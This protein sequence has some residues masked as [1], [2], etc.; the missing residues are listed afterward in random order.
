[1]TANNAIPVEGVDPKS[2]TAHEQ[3][4]RLYTL[5]LTYGLPTTDSTDIPA[6]VPQGAEVLLATR[7][8][9]LDTDQRR[10]V[11]RTTAISSDNLLLDDTEGWGRLNLYAAADG[12][13]RFDTEPT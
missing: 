3:E 9:Y 10:E 7:Q 12:Y 11:L 8:P 2:L 6:T 4:K 1:V 5:R 13:G